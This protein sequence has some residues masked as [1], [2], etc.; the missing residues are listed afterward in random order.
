MNVDRV[1]VVSQ[2]VNI[3]MQTHLFLDRIFIPGKTTIIQTVFALELDHE[4]LLEIGGGLAHD[5]MVC[6]LENV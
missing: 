1:I 5:L 2:K 4:S 6:V 3:C